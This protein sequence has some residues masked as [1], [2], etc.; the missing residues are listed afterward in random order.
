MLRFLPPLLFL[1]MVAPPG[2]EKIL[3]RDVD[4]KV[5]GD[6]LDSDDRASILFFV[7]HD[8]PISNRFAPRSSGFAKLMLRADFS[9]TWCTWTRI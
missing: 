6:L 4:G 9:V 3:L 1:V 7:T 2:R 5:L 8:C